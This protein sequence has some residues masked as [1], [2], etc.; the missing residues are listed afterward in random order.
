[1]IRE[2][3]LGSDFIF[4]RD[5]KR[6]QSQVSSLQ[7]SPRAAPAAAGTPLVPALAPKSSRGSCKGSV[8]QP[9]KGRDK[10]QLTVFSLQQSEAQQMTQRSPTTTPNS[11]NNQSCL[12]MS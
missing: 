9:K 7:L 3:P 1:M 6:L 11:P 10:L 12:P 4:V 2:P 8:L 5:Q